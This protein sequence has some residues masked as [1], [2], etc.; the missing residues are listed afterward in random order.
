M[1]NN[2]PDGELSGDMPQNPDKTS[3]QH[4]NHP[5]GM[6]SLHP[7]DK[8]RTISDINWQAQHVRCN[9]TGSI[10]R[11][12][13]DLHHNAEARGERFFCSIEH[14]TSRNSHP[15]GPYS[16]VPL[17]D[18]EQ[19][20]LQVEIHQMHKSSS[21]DKAV[22]TITLPVTLYKDVINEYI[23]ATQGNSS[24]NHLYA[25]NSA[26]RAREVGGEIIRETLRERH[27]EASDSLAKALFIA[28]AELEQ[29]SHK[30]H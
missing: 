6:A 28:M 11:H 13:S 30:K 27:L 25:R 1:L 9:E 5:I 14:G 17:W 29:S 4:A 18:N 3:A 23:S 12:L 7:A 21:D 8:A 10:M 2:T 16:L 26:I 19:H 15:Q 24:R 22:A 20:T